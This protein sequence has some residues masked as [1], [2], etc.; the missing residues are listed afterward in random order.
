MKHYFSFAIMILLTFSGSSQTVTIY[1]IITHPKDKKVY[2]RYY[3]DYLTWEE[4]TID[5]ATLDKMGNF[6]MSFPWKG[7]YPADFYHGDEMTSMYLIPGD[8]LKLSLDTKAFD[9]TLK[10]GGKGSDVNNYMA[11]KFLQF[12]NVSG[13]EYNLGENDFTK[14]IDSVH[15]AELEHFNQYWAK[16]PLK[17]PAVDAFMDY[18]L[19]EINYGWGGAKSEYPGLYAYIN[20]LKE[21]LIVSEHYYD[22]MKKLSV[23]NPKAMLS[24]AYLEYV[25]GYVNSE[26]RKLFQQDST[27]KYFDVKQEFVE[28]NF[29]GSLKEYVFANWIY[30]LLTDENNIAKA[31]P[32]FEKYIKAVKN[33]MYSSI[34]EHV[35]SNASLLAVGN[36][37]P[38]F[39]CMDF[40]GNMVS[41]S[42][43]KGKVVYLDIWASW[44]G[45]C[46]MEIP[47]ARKLEG[48]LEGK[49]VI[50]LCVSIDEDENAWRKI[51]AEK[52]MKGVHLISKGSFASDVAKL[53]N[54]TGIPH[55][56]IIDQEGNIVNINAKRP[57]EGVQE[58]LEQLIK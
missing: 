3:K 57:S 31:K 26:T 58:E 43:F 27:R 25:T 5:S 12:P 41:L 38:D 39:K 47:Y 18:A 32:L 30:D 45:P 23:N 11:Q 21:P 8:S 22:Y 37:A 46:R 44:C 13:N 19:A 15:T 24:S 9:E 35:M 4:Q 36:L 17:S 16:I 49:N 42:D 55:Y 7:A 33:N 53:Y 29:S 48:K 14:Y 50:F 40:D 54:V 51:I 56:I 10:Y 34:L 1:G 2:V 20:Q 6:S 28:Q 52:E